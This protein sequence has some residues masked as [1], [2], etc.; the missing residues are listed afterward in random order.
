MVKETTSYMERQPTEWE[1]NSAS[2]TSD[3]GLLVRIY[4]ELKNVHINRLNDKIEK[5]AWDLKRILKTL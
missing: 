4:E 5:W 3:R 1:N 2:C